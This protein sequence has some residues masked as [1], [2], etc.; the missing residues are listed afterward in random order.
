M[1]CTKAA[2]L[3]R[4]GMVELGVKIDGRSLHNLLPRSIASRL[5]LH[6]YFGKS[7]QVSIAHHMILTNQY[8][9]FITRVANYAT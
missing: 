3:S 9:Q 7:I 4:R 8:Y 2:V 1:L 6:L 5:R